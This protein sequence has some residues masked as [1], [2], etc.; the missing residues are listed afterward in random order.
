[1]R[2]VDIA[3]RTV[4]VELDPED[5][6]LLAQACQSAAQYD[7][8]LWKMHGPAPVLGAL[9]FAFDA[10]AMAA[11]AANDLDDHR[12]QPVTLA[13]VRKQVQRFG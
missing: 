12:E 4:T 7:S 11:Q 1:M 13:R 8:E 3:Q 9:A 6:V 2:L 5:C 10:A